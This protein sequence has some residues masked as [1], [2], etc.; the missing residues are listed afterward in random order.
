M[1]EDIKLRNPKWIFK[2]DQVTR[3]SGGRVSVYQ[4]IRRTEDKK[5]FNLISRYP[6]IHHL[7]T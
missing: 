6:D 4:E 5:L 7:I 3:K 2:G 1:I